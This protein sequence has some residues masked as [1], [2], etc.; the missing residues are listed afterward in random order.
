MIAKRI[1]FLKVMGFRP[2]VSFSSFSSI[3]ISE[4]IR[5]GKMPTDKVKVLQLINAAAKH[6][7][8]DSMYTGLSYS[9]SYYYNILNSMRSL[10]TPVVERL[11]A[12]SYF[13]DNPGV[14]TCLALELVRRNDAEGKHF[15]LAPCVLVL[16]RGHE[17][18][19]AGFVDY[20]SVSKFISE[21]T[22]ANKVHTEVMSIVFQI[23]MNGGRYEDIVGAL[24][25]IM[26]CGLNTIPLSPA[27][28]GEVISMLHR[29]G[30]GEGALEF[31]TTMDGRLKSELMS[32][33]NNHNSFNNYTTF[34]ESLSCHPSNEK[35][36]SRSLGESISILHT[37]YNICSRRTTIL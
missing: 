24:Y 28:F 10:S 35:H 11:F 9:R 2:S 36:V 37:K 12:T 34:I 5:T 17:N 31:V 7:D 33:I 29:K 26:D 20:Q 1:R 8:L 32:D 14:S 25:S 16:S 23:W 13:S 4:L 30:H 22:C 19:L 15:H 18:A 27:T 6:N 21:I 3:S